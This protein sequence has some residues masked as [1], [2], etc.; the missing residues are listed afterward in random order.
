[1][2]VVVNSTLQARLPD[3]NGQCGWWQ[4]TRGG[5]DYAR[6]HLYTDTTVC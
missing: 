6:Q 5:K 2:L 1:M 4:H 3:G